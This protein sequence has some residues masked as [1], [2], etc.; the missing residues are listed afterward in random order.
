[1]K[2]SF[3]PHDEDTWNNNHVGIAYNGPSDGELNDNG[4]SFHNT[5]TWGHDY[6]KHLLW[7]LDEEKKL[8]ISTC[9]VKNK[10]ASMIL[11]N[12]CEY[13]IW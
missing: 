8:T 2:P 13:C 12:E 11:V 5:F 1:M 3:Y 4:S 10:K 6:A 9:W 7:N